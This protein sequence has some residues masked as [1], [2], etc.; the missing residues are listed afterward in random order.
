MKKTSRSQRE[1]MK[2][3][4]IKKKYPA[5]K[6]DAL[7]QKLHKSGVFYYDPDFPNDD[8]ERAPVQR[9]HVSQMCFGKTNRSPEKS[10]P[11]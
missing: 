3:R 7:I 10:T 8:E 11:P 6:A 1:G 5:A 9:F 4:D 2:A